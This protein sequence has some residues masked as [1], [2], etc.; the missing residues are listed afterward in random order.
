MQK[1]AIFVPTHNEAEALASTLSQIPEEIC[2][3]LRDIIVVDDCSSDGT[4]EIARQF[5]P[6]VICLN[7]NRGVGFA[8]KV[9]LMHIS[10]LGEYHHVVKLDGDGQH[11]PSFIKSVVQKLDKG[12]DLAIVS[13]FHPLSDQAHTP[14]NRILL[15]ATFTGMVRKIT[16]LPLT[17]SRSGFMGFHFQDVQR[18]APHLIVERYGIPMELILRLWHLRWSC[19]RP[20]SVSEIPH[21]AKYGGE[22]SKKL[23]AKYHSERIDHKTSRLQMAYEALLTVL[24]DLKVPREL[25]L[26]AYGLMHY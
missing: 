16:K 13:R 12:Y 9:G 24:E 26:E 23:K 3:F 21:P 10:K 6:H 4:P 22:I 1:I 7:E 2:G 17:D 18:I 8:T 20:I 11:N 19:D 14:L 25:I 5:T 15:N